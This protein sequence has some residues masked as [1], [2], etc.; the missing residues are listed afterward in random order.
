MGLFHM[1]KLLKDP[2]LYFLLIGAALFL[3]FGLFKD[4]AGNQENSVVITRGDIEF[5]KANFARTWRRPPTE[6]ELANLIDDKVRDEISY[7]EAVA[8][9]L[10]Q[11]DPVIRKRLRMKVEL[12]AEDIAGL[13]SPSDEDLSIFLEKNRDSFRREP[14]ISFKHVYL[15]SDK[16][17]ADVENDARDLLAKLSAVGPGAAPEAYGDPIMLPKEFTLDYARNVE[18]LFGKSFSR[19][20]LQVDPGGWAGP[21][22]SS[23]GHHLVFVRERVAARHPELSEIRQ[24]VEREWTAKRR[25]DVKEKMHKKLREQYTITIEKETLPSDSDKK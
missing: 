12:L 17:G 1:K 2:L 23:Y 10:D 5:I 4:P 14:Q 18:R 7:R 6:K 21:V 16:R 22:R 3:I 20:L 13:A 8:M 24:E 11:D 19:D 25:R 9:G 15:S